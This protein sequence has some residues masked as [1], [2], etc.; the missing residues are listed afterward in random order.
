M[1]LF[2]L[3]VNFATFMEPKLQLSFGSNGTSPHGFVDSILK[4]SL[5]GFELLLFILSMKINPGSA[6]S[7]AQSIIFSHNSLAFILS[8]S[9]PHKLHLDSF[10]PGKTF[11]LH[12]LH[13]KTSSPVLGL[14][15]LW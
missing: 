3:F 5:T 12:L 1:S 4:C 2:S 10:C 13:F 14:I 8:P 11:F 6:H 7:H 15:N 9:P